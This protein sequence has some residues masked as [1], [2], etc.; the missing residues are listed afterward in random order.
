M[1]SLLADKDKIFA[2]VDNR[3]G[4]GRG[5]KANVDACGRGHRADKILLKLCLCG[6][7]KRMPLY[8]NIQ[9]L[10]RKSVAVCPRSYHSYQ[11]SPKLEKKQFK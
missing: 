6:R 10:L 3:T 4:G 11:V 2:D 5:V 1:Q 9:N 8:S 7:H